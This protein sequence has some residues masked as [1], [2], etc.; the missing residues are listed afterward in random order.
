MEIGETSGS[1][2]RHRVFAVRG[3]ADVMEGVAGG[4]WRA[5][6]TAAATSNVGRSRVRPL[7]ALPEGLDDQAGLGFGVQAPEGPLSGLLL[8]PGNSDE[9]AVEGEVVANGIL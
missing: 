1:K 4:S 7:T 8:G 3:I 6:T 5:A 9:V 2:E